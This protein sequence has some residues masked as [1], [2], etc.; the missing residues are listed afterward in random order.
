MI[1]QDTQTSESTFKTWHTIASIGFV[2]TLMASA[3]LWLSRNGEDGIQPSVTTNEAR[4]HELGIVL[5]EVID[6]DHTAI[7]PAETIQR[8]QA[9]KFV[10][11]QDL[12]R[13]NVFV[14]KGVIVESRS[15]G[16]IRILHG[17]RVGD[18]IV[19]SGAERLRV[20]PGS[21][22]KAAETSGDTSIKQETK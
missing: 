9:G 19:I 3:Y 18:Q 6:P 5:R 15:D 4:V 12:A 22:P 20:E 21:Q 17:I 1:T 8:D 11:A 16:R 2:L 10:F 7:V 14:R 13:P